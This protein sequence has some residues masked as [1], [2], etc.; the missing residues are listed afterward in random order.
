[1][2]N[3]IAQDSYSSIDDPDLKLIHSHVE[4]YGTQS[5]S[6]FVFQPGVHYFTSEFGVLCYSTQKTPWGVTNVVFTNP[7]CAAKNTATLLAHYFRTVGTPT[8]FIGVD[9]FVSDILI[10]M[11][12][13]CNQIGVE[14]EI[15]L[16]AFTLKGSDKKQIR[17]ASNFGKRT[18]ACVK[19][20]P[21]YEVDKAQV[22]KI[23]RAWRDSKRTASREL[24]LLTRPPVFAQENPVRKFYCFQGDTLLGYVFFE[25]YYRQGKIIGY[26]ANIIRCLPGKESGTVSDYIILEAMKKFKAEG[27]AL[28]SLGISPLAAVEPHP[29]EHK[30][31]RN[32]AR[33]LFKNGNKLYAFQGLAYH[34]SRYRPTQSTWYMCTPNLPVL[35]IVYTVLFSTGIINIPFLERFS[36]G[37][38]SVVHNDLVGS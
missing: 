25:P 10:R 17:H 23:S 34:K 30:S 8:I 3:E 7:L 19:E 15:D 4:L 37:K 38:R 36:L 1:M 26:C 14:S 27:V 12:H 9:Q 22:S 24:R 11:G 2:I 6:R 31:I 29:G 28:L 35:Q 20:L 21:W 33:W 32:L 16:S 5:S 13:R 18:G